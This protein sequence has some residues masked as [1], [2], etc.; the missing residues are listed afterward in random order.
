MQ[1][2]LTELE[3]PPALRRRVHW[4]GDLNT[5]HNEQQEEAEWYGNSGNDI[6]T[7]YTFVGILVQV[8][9]FESKTLDQSRDRCS[10]CAKAA[11]DRKLLHCGNCLRVAYCDKQCQKQHWSKEHKTM[12]AT[13]NTF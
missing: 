9:P 12:C 8:P 1:E 13:L 4:C 7:V 6:A 2:A 5:T 11:H 3:E 10:H